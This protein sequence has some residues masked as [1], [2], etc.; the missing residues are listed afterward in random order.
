MLAYKFR[1]SKPIEWIT[2]I[3]KKKELYCTDWAKFNDPPEAR[4]YYLEEY[5]QRPSSLV[6]L[7]E[8]LKVCSLSKSFRSRLLWAHYANG[9][10]GAPIEID[11]PESDFGKTLHQV[12]YQSRSPEAD[13]HDNVSPGK[14]ARY[15]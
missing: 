4:F 6:K 13:L 5:S 14:K 11:L 15:I 9:F 7:K 2:D 3:I 8:Q 10:D 12:V 1:S